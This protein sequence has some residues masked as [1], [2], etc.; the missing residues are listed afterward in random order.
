LVAELSNEMLSPSKVELDV[1]DD[2]EE[3]IPATAPAAPAA[4]AAPEIENL[5]SKYN[6]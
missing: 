6:Y 4:P 5:R 2:T 1:D 3:S